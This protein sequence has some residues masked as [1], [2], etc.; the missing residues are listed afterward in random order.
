MEKV[1][2]FVACLWAAKQTERLMLS[3][4]NVADTLNTCW[5]PIILVQEDPQNR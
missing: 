3:T 4:A 5:R 1:K 2:D